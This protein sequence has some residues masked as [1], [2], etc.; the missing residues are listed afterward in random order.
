LYS[1]DPRY[2][3][4]FTSVKAKYLRSDIFAKL[5]K[6]R[7]TDIHQDGLQAVQT[8]TPK[9][10]SGID[11]T[12]D[13]WTWLAREGK[14]L[15][16]SKERGDEEVSVERTNDVDIK[17]LAPDGSDLFEICGIGIRMLEELVKSRRQMNFVP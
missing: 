1:A 5:H 17:C 6:L 12:K 3:E 14:F 15:I 16:H 11:L 10:D 2:S 7:D 9:S 4:W 13:S 8:L